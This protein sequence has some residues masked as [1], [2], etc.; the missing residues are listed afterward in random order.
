[1]IILKKKM[2]RQYRKIKRNFSFRPQNIQPIYHSKPAFLLT[3]K[4]TKKIQNLTV[5]RKKTKL[6]TYACI[7]L[8]RK[9]E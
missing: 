4:D 5:R 1:M 7:T 8:G 9:T 3:V 2:E 6:P